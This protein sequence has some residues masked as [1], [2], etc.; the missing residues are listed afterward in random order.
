MSNTSTDNKNLTLADISEQMGISLSTAA[1]QNFDTSLQ[2]ALPEVNEHPEDTQPLARKPQIKFLVILILTSLLV[3]FFG[4]FLMGTGNQTQSSS[5]T[6]APTPEF[7]DSKEAEIAE[8]KSRL[9]LESQKEALF[10]DKPQPSPTPSPT[11]SQTVPLPQNLATNPPSSTS[12]SSKSRE[13]AASRQYSQKGLP[14]VSHSVPVATPSRTSSQPNIYRR[15]RDLGSVE[16]AYVDSSRY[17]SNTIPISYKQPR[18][19]TNRDSPYVEKTKPATAPT[20]APSISGTISSD[21][22]SNSRSPTP[23]IEPIDSL[24]P[25]SNEPPEN[26]AIPNEQLK[27]TIP[28][29]P[30]G[31]RYKGKLASPLQMVR[32]EAGGESQSKRL[33][34]VTTEPMAT[35]RGW[36]IPAG[37]MVAM[38]IDIASNGLVT[39]QSESVWYGNHSVSLPPGALVLA[40]PDDNPLIAKA[41]RPDSGKEA[42]RAERE[43]M[44][45]GSL[46]KIG[47]VLSEPDTRVTVNTG[48]T[49]A[50]SVNNGRKNILG[51]VLDGAFNSRAQSKRDEA[52]RRREQSLLQVPIWHLPAGTEVVLIADAVDSALIPSVAQSYPQFQSSL[53][54]RVTVEEIDVPEPEMKETNIASVE[55]RVEEIDVPEPGM[56]ESNCASDRW[57]NRSYPHL[58]KP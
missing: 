6:P 25:A 45:W 26:N 16:T 21:I 51:A 23:T 39:G 57:G 20:S 50:T 13:D 37:A 10:G 31:S 43:A 7:V 33:F 32:E 15:G 12:I 8:L 44:L 11:P 55:P 34:I 52:V 1:R 40:S 42:N 48:G 35:D 19:S 9:G 18:Y 36:Q 46:G 28:M 24:D 38:K 14:G 54:D 4:V 29:L 56:E 58:C 17:R 3:G 27:E 30:V 22:A 5:P 49:I 41:I 53:G 47:Q 2:Q